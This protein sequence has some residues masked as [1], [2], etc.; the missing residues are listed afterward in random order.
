MK[1]H[2][3]PLVRSVALAVLLGNFG[4]QAA[5]LTL[6]VAADAFIHAGSADN[7]AGGWSWFGAGRDGVG[8][9]RRGLVRFDVSGIPAG[10]TVTSVVLRLTL[11]QVPF[12]GPV[13]SNFDLHRLLATW[14]EGNK[15]S[16]GGSGG[17][18]ATTGEATWNSRQHGMATWTSPGVLGDVAATASASTL[19]GSVRGATHSWSGSGL[20]SD[21]EEWIANPSEVYFKLI[22]TN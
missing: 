18:P 10:A 7:N 9:V 5:S 15:A 21:V 11:D 19:V 14:G 22:I 6:P 8:G 20:I 12:Q 16:A 1:P 17:L 4:A 2:Q 3:N 13:N